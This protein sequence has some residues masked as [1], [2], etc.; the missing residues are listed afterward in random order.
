MCNNEFWLKFE[1]LN[2]SNKSGSNF[3]HK[4]IL[5]FLHL[6]KFNWHVV[7]CHNSNGNIWYML[8]IFYMICVQF[9]VWTQILLHLEEFLNFYHIQKKNLWKWVLQ[10]IFH[11][12]TFTPSW[13]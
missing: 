3:I 10:A 4:E 11:N 5:T 13:N 8:Q 2:K 6:D 9:Y 12:A 1:K 7:L